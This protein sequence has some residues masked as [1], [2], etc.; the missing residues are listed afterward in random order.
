MAGG[1]NRDSGAVT[2]TWDLSRPTH[3]RNQD[4]DDLAMNSTYCT[5]FDQTRRLRMRKGVGQSEKERERE[6]PRRKVSRTHQRHL[7]YANLQ[8]SIIALLCL[9]RSKQNTINKNMLATRRVYRVQRPI[10]RLGFCIHS[11]LYN[12]TKILWSRT[13]IYPYMKAQHH[14]EHIIHT[15]TRT[16]THIAFTHFLCNHKVARKDR[17]I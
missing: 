1:R 14:A 7:L 4:S 16:H 10:L 11:I 15:H 5:C 3:S 8:V 6:R 2:S 12:Y 9:N 17:D 13:P